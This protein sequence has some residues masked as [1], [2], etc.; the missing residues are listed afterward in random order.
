MINFATT[1]TMKKL[2][3]ETQAFIRLHAQDNIKSLALQAAKYPNVD[4]REAI[5]QISGRQASASKIPSW[6]AVDGLLYPRHLSMEQCSSEGTARYKSSLVSGSSFTDLTGGFGV[7]CAFLASGFEEAHYVE[8]QEELCEIATHN[9]PL[10]GLPYIK[11]HNT[12]SV[13]YLEQM[14]PVDWIFIDPARRDGHGGKTVA[15]SDCEPNV[16]ELEELLASKG[17]KVMV[18]LSPMLDIARALTTLKHI[19]EV[20]IVSAA[21]EC[22]ELLLVLNRQAA[23]ADIPMHCINLPAVGEMQSFSFTREAEQQATCNYTSSLKRYLYEPN[24]SILKAGGFKS[25]AAQ[26]QVEKLH[27]N[28]HLYTSD[29]LIADFPG[30]AFEVMNHCTFNKKEIKELLGNIKKANLTIRN[31]PT[32]VA[33]L[34]KRIKLAEGGDDYLFATTLSNDKRV[35]VLC[36]KA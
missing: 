2:S 31:F 35:L 27:P 7:D 9:F 18:K 10:L 21:N 1:E 32:T 20:H 23:S 36:K 19:S 8:R 26:Y 17:R 12:E 24:A 30:R 15:I 33:E 22:K 11:V 6:Q 13:A 5:T 16:E 3:E 25:I 29:S 28:S 34:R 4:M 14:T